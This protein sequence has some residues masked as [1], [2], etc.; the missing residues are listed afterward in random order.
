MDLLSPSSEIVLW[1]MPCTHFSI[2]DLF[3]SYADWM[4][5]GR[6]EGGEKDE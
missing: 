5:P 4:K 6:I 1:R 2:V 3:Y